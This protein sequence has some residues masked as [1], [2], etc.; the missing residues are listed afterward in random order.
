MLSNGKGP[1]LVQSVQT[2]AERICVQIRNKLKAMDLE[3]KEFAKHNE[4]ASEAAAPV[5]TLLR[6]QAN[7]AHFDQVRIR[8]NM[9]GTLTRKFVDLMAEYQEIQT[10]CRCFLWPTALFF[11]STVRVLH[12]WCTGVTDT[13]TST[14]TESNAVCSH[15]TLQQPHD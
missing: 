11:I 14:A 12:F 9:H 8:S 2:C 6:P 7:R 1:R 10:K 3:N 4:G 13:K 15:A 5:V